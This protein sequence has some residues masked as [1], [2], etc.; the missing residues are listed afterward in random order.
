MTS[1]TH[2]DALSEFQ[3]NTIITPRPDG[4]AFFFVRVKM[5]DFDLVESS[6]EKAASNLSNV[7]SAT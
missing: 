2:C 4:M 7:F 1:V 6:A 5:V 3:I